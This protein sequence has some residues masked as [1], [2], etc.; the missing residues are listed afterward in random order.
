MLYTAIKSG[1]KKF[2]EKEREIELARKEISDE[3]NATLNKRLWNYERDMKAFKAHFA[4][5]DH[6]EALR[7]D[8]H[9]ITVYK[10]NGV[11]KFDRF[12]DISQEDD[13]FGLGS[14]YHNI[15]NFKGFPQGLTPSL[16]RD[17]TDYDRRKHVPKN[18]EKVTDEH[19]RKRYHDWYC[20]VHMQEL[21]IKN[22]ISKIQGDMYEAG[23]TIFPHKK[24]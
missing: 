18:L 14:S 17:L 20:V 10:N 21:S 11:A 2:D 24:D 4:G 19:V 6:I 22:R 13:Y 16:I 8:L 15:V 12:E 7:A 1:F 5:A 23:K 9:K 3:F